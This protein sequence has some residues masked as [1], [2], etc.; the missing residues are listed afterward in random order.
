MAA[1][2]ILIDIINYFHQVLHYKSDLFLM[3]I[4]LFL[5]FVFFRHA[6]NC[7]KMEEMSKF[8][9]TR[10]SITMFPNK[11]EIGHRLLWVSGSIF[12]TWLMFEYYL[13]PDFSLIDMIHAPLFYYGCTV[14]HY[15]AVVDP[16]PPAKSKVRQWTEKL[17]LGLLKP[18]PVET[19]N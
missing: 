9:E 12:G 13:S 7:D 16:L 10:I 1:T 5:N 11:K 4:C 15:F 17:S 2:N 6:C 18:V 8:S 14:F 3:S 19:E